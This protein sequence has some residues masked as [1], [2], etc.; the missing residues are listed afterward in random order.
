MGP[1]AT[2]RRDPVGT[3][4]DGQVLSAKQL[5]QMA[6][7]VSNLVYQSAETIA[8]L[9]P[10]QGLKLLWMK[11]ST[12]EEYTKAVALFENP[13]Q[14]ILHLSVRGTDTSS[15]HDI[16]TA[17]QAQPQIFDSQLAPG[18]MVHPGFR[19][20]A[21]DIV[22]DIYHQL[23][24]HGHGR[25]LVVSG[26]SA[27]AAIASICI[28]QLQMKDPALL[29]NLKVSAVFFGPAVTFSEDIQPLIPNILILSFINRGDPVPST[30]IDYCAWGLRRLRAM[31]L[32]GLHRFRRGPPQWLF[33]YLSN[34]FLSSDPVR[35][36]ERHRRVLATPPPAQRLFPV[37]R[38]LYLNKHRDRGVTRYSVTTLSRAEL[39]SLAPWRIDRHLC[40]KYISALKELDWS[41]TS[42]NHCQDL[43]V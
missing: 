8:K 14:G 25:P 39:S 7:Q 18:L 32:L 12:Q 30:D 2:R 16:I 27:G 26:H 28:L 15:L 40:H 20:S 37:G 35:G 36:A 38:L 3:T 41:S 1:P 9:A 33:G 34:F 23:R 13:R 43:P 21:Q 17:T 6:A 19:E 42:G 22:E 4:P 11:E 31:F 29:K 5:C 10:S 24:I